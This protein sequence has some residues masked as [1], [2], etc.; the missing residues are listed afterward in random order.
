M[1][2]LDFTN[3]TDSPSKDDIN[4]PEIKEYPKK[5]KLSLEKDVLG[6]Y[7]TD[8]PLSDVS[9]NLS[10]IINFE[11]SF[12]DDL[13]DMEIQRLD[14]KFVTMAGIITGKSE[15]MTKSRSLMSF[16][17]LEDL[18]GSIEMVIFPET[19]RKYR[20][21]VEDDNVVVVKGKLQ[22]DENDV[23]LLTSEFIDIESMNLKTLYLKTNF[24]RYNELKGLLQAN[25]GDT[26]VVI[27]FEDKNKSVKLDQKLWVNI[28][29]NELEKL[30]EFLG[31]ENVKLN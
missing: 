9:D 22:V 29:E 30:Y 20:N 28:N 11:T 4:M 17:N 16:A 14:N 10:H 8:H 3:E 26:P 13:T 18:Y 7:I 15:I 12:R 5:V 6:F 19:Y 21:L 25:T 2:L 27:Y 23:K 24:S 31:K 1:N